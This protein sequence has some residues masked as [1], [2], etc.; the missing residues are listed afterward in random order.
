M[1]SEDEIYFVSCTDV[2]LTE[3]KTGLVTLSV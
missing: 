1:I 3:R 2:R